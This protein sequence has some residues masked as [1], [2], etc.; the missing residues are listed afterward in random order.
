[1]TPTLWMLKWGSALCLIGSVAVF[2]FGIAGDPQSLPHR[3]VS[4][5][6]AYLERKLR[7]MFITT[8]G[9]YIVGGQ[10]AA[11]AVC[12]ALAAV[13]ENV[14]LVLLVPI[15]VFGPALHIE[16]MRKQRLASIEARMDV[17]IL[18]LANALKST[19]SIGSALIQV[20]PLVHP[21]MDQ[22]VALAL[23]EMRVGSSLDQA[24]MNMA[25]RIRSVQLDAALSG[26]LI[27]RQVG[28]DLTNILETTASTL[29][30]MGRLHGVVRSKT[31]EGKAQLLILAVFPAGILLLFDMVSDGYFEPLGKS[32]VGWAIVVVAIALWV[33][34]LAVA[35]R[36]LTV[37]I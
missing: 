1:M 10:A 26:L 7:N 8:P 14:Y 11:V 31:A 35:R 21:P 24:L 9:R 3:Y 29:R 19:P 33:T 4:L 36:V 20:Q 34:S 6:V 28:G 23:K 5:Y 18:A 12:A 37:D 27:G 2:A 17:F 13:L 16:R 32:L 22:E 25:G 15:V 30:E